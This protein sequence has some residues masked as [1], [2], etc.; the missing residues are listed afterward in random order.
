MS[1]GTNAPWG[2]RPV[3]YFNGAAWNDQSGQYQ[4]ASGYATNL[5]RGDPLTAAVAADGTVSIAT[6]GDG[7]VILGVFWACQYTATTG[8]VVFSQTWTA[9]TATFGATP[10]TV[11]VIDDPMVIFNVQGN[12]AGGGIVT[13]NLLRNASLVAGAGSAYSGLSGWMLSQGTIG[14]GAT[15]QLKILRFVPTATGTNI[16][17]L[18]YNNVEALINNS[19]FKAGVAS[20]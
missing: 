4:F 3:R 17:G 5:F 2:L 11:F 1:Y 9:G 14:A 19:Y 15:K 13:A 16:S 7:N 18:Q 8:E 10:V 6:A 20:V 12:G